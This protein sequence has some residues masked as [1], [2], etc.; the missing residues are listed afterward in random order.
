MRFRF[1]AL[2]FRMILQ[3]TYSVKWSLN[4]KKTSKRHFYFL[5][6]FNNFSFL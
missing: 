3:S 5:V 4:K 2:N 6:L 1:V